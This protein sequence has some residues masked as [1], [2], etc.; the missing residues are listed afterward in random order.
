MVK[1]SEVPEKAVCQIDRRLNVMF[2][3]QAFG[4]GLSAEEARK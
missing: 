4:D 2:I 1:V 3:F